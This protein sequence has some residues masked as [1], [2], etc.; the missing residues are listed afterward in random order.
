VTA[1]GVWEWSTPDAG[2]A[3]GR[4]VVLGGSVLIAT[5]DPCALERTMGVETRDYLTGFRFVI[6]RGP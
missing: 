4:A 2:T 1:G 5:D 3:D 6:E